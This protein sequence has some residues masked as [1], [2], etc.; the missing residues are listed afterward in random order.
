MSGGGWWGEAYQG[1]SF[2]HLQRKERRG[3]E[4]I[5]T[6][7]GTFAPCNRFTRWCSGKDSVCQCRR[8]KRLGFH[9]WV[10][11][12]PWRRA[13][14]PIPGFLPGE[15]HGQKSLR[16][17]SPWD[18]KE[19][20]TTEWLSMHARAWSSSIFATGTD[21]ENCLSCTPFW[22]SSEDFLRHLTK[23]LSILDIVDAQ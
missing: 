3:R 16:G 10:G 11:K 23:K 20:D 6:V 8:H 9:P 5:L 13:W 15:S 12:I 1:C 17:Y 4:R 18:H 21:R 7:L 14:Q 22:G 2:A 19:S